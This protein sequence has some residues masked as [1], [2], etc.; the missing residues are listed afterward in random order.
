MSKAGAKIGL[1]AMP[2]EDAASGL[3]AARLRMEENWTCFEQPVPTQTLSQLTEEAEAC[4]ISG[5]S[6]SESGVVPEIIS[7]VAEIKASA[8]WWAVR[9][10][11]LTTDYV[12]PAQTRPVNVISGCTGISAESWALKARGHVSESRAKGGRWDL[13]IVYNSISYNWAYVMY[14]QLRGLPVLFLAQL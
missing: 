3:R 10:A 8:P 1:L 13:V 9:M 6:K 5:T 12:P 4:Y 2:E 11:Q 14:G 7:P